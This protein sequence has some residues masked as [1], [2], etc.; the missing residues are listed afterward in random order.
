MEGEGK[1]EGRRREGEENEKRGWRL[2]GGTDEVDEKGRRK[3]K[4]GKEREMRR[5]REG[6][7]KEM[8]REGEGKEKI[9]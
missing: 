1:E 3:E 8:R 4:D 5:D 7:A 2:R 9:V 6:K